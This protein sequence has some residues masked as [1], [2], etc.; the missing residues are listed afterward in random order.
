[1]DG[2]SFLNL[3]DA[4]EFLLITIL[5]MKLKS[6]FDENFEE[7]ENL[8]EDTERVRR[9]ACLVHAAHRHAGTEPGFTG[10]FSAIA[11]EAC[12]TG[13]LVDP[14]LSATTGYKR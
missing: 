5:R 13:I 11:K 6:H 7:V 10:H 4:E 14:A 3:L 12:L 8:R 2:T 9:L 1:M